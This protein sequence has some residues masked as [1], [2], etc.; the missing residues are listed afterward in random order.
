MFILK[1][2][3]SRH[4]NRQKG[5]KKMVLSQDDFKKFYLKAFGI[6]DVNEDKGIF[7]FQCGAKLIDKGESLVCSNSHSYKYGE[8][9]LEY[10]RMLKDFYDYADDIS[11]T[12]KEREEYPTDTLFIDN[13]VLLVDGKFLV[14]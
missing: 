11:F 2:R 6:E 10:T 13:K 4:K 3:I 9:L 1:N 8:H 5:V 12:S 7:C 14:I